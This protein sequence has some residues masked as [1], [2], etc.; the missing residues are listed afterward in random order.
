MPKKLFNRVARSLTRLPTIFLSFQTPHSHCSTTIIIPDNMERDKK[1]HQEAIANMAAAA[2]DV[3]GAHVPI[4]VTPTG[5]CFPFGMGFQGEDHLRK[6]PIDRAL[7]E[8]LDDPKKG[9]AF[10]KKD[11]DDRTSRSLR[12]N[13]LRCR[14]DTLVKATDYKK[15][16]TLYL[17]GA[18]AQCGTTLPP[19]HSRSSLYMNLDKVWE[20]EDVVACYT[21]AAK[22][23]MK[24][25]DYAQV[26][27]CFCVVISHLI[28]S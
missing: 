22:A 26:R 12:C 24:L 17:A 20:A 4:E 15:A 19:R 2:K 16:V 9:D 25:R 14:A 18:E 23:L 1:L 6:R 10:L 13:L 3:F 28:L 27:Y 7:R 21:G 8:M 11:G 5:I